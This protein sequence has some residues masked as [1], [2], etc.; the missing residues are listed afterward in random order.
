MLFVIGYLLFAIC[1]GG[2]WAI[3]KR[4]NSEQATFFVIGYL[5]FVIWLGGTWAI[6]LCVR[7]LIDYWLLVIGYWVRREKGDRF[8]CQKTY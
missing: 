2:T 8:V 6:A 4:G 1:F 7:K 3:A 5:L